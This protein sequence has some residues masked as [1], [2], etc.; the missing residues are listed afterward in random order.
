MLKLIGKSLAVV[1]VIASIFCTAYADD[2]ADMA[3]AIEK[4]QNDLKNANSR[5]EMIKGSSDAD[6]AAAQV[7]SISGGGANEQDMYSLAAD[8]MGNM[9]GMSQEQIM[10]TM[11]QAQKDPEAFL[12]TWSPEQRKKL[13][14]LSGRLPASKQKN[15]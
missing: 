15:P 3:S 13:E 1:L 6:K 8:V 9:K 2:A 12:K 7:K 11:Q 14:E 5:A 10:Q 4:T